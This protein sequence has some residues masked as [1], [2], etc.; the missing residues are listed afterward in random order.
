MQHE[1]MI[2]LDPHNTQNSLPFTQEAIRQHYLSYH[3]TTAK[4]ISYTKLDASAGFAF[5]LRRESDLEILKTFMENGK[6]EHRQNWIFNPVKSKRRLDVSTHSEKLSSHGSSFD[7]LD[8]LVEQAVAL[9]PSVE[10][11]NPMRLSRRR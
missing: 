10:D 6:R 3:E 11:L 5:L 8:E 1:H 4:R 9:K 2:F 7:C